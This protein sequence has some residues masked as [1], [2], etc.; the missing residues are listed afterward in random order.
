M[1]YRK[2]W[3]GN[4]GEIPVD[5]NNRSYEI[6]HIDGNHKNNNID[7]LKCV[8]IQEHYD[9]HYNQKDYG[10]CVCIAKR[11]NLPPD[12]LSSIQL[13]KK[14]PGVGGRKK[15]SISKI[16]VKHSE[17]TKRKMSEN[18]KGKV[19]S[20]KF[21]EEQIQLLL[22]KFI[23]TPIFDP[24]KCKKSGMIITHLSKFINENYIEFGMSKTTMRNIIT[25]KTLVWKNLFDQIVNLKY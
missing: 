8:S 6:H 10:A 12:F 15:G 16:K 13:G 2:I 9:I 22:E 11:M 5:E 7:N 25:G 24:V 1:N 20:K 18:R 23:S 17:E 21:T 14:R 4:F 19:H 3:I